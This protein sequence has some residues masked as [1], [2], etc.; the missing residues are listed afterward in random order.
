MFAW[1]AIIFAGLWLVL[2]DVNPVAKAKL[3]GQPLLIHALVVIGSGLWIHDACLSRRL[4]APSQIAEK[5]RPRQSGCRSPSAVGIRCKALQATF[6]LT[7]KYPSWRSQRP[8]REALTEATVASPLQRVA[9]AN[10]SPGITPGSSACS[11]CESLRMPS[12]APRLD[13]W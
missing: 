3:M 11:P 4:P 9:F 13:P 6:Y 8:R 1:R 12:P 5:K 10:G 7:L 2:R